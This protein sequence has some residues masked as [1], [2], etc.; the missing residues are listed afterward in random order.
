[1]LRV[2]RVGHE[3]GVRV[4]GAQRR[5]PGRERMFRAISGW[6]L[7]FIAISGFEVWQPSVRWPVTTTGPG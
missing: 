6:Q 2:E 4:L 1:M 3:A 7:M 5:A